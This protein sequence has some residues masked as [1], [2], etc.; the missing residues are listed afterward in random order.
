MA[1]TLFYFLLLL[2][3]SPDYTVPINFDNASEDLFFSLVLSPTKYRLGFISHLASLSHVSFSCYFCWHFT[4]LHK[5]EVKVQS[6][7]LMEF[8]GLFSVFAWQPPPFQHKTRHVSSY[9]YFWDCEFCLSPSFQTLVWLLC[10]YTDFTWVG[11][12][13]RLPTH[14]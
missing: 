10:N 5:K 3:S 14:R 9:C 12:K 2:S 6:S 7:K 13:M 1:L 11:P 4:F 8:L